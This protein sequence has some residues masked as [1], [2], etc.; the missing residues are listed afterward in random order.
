VVINPEGVMSMRRCLGLLLAA[1]V[2]AALAIAL[3]AAAPAATAAGWNVSPGG[4]FT[5]KQSGDVTIADTVTGKSVVCTLTTVAGRFKSGT[6]LSGTGI[7]KLRS[8]ALTGCATAK[9][10]AF[11]VTAGALPWSLNAVMYRQAKATT[12]GTLTGMHITL[13]ATGCSATIDG[14]SATS[15]NGSVV[16]HI[17]NSPSKLKFEAAGATLHVYV[18]SGCTGLFKNADAVTVDNA[19]LVSPAQTVTESS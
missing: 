9:G 3:G 6:G 11:T 10:K 18:A 7:G 12:N 15:D 13:A 17:H 14:T 4:S 16:I 1:A 5:G 2:A 8:L 19:Y